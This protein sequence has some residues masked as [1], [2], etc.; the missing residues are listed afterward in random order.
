MPLRVTFELS[1]KDLRHFRKIMAA[2]REMARDKDEEAIIGAAAQLLQNVADASV[3]QF[4]AVRLDRLRTLIDMLQD[5]EWRIPQRERTRVLNALAYFADPQ[6]LIPDQTP[7]LGFLD[8]AIMI[9][10][11]A[12][13]LRHEIEAYE[14]FCRFR[15]ENG[16]P[17]DANATPTNR[18]ERLSARRKALHER[19]RR[20]RSER[21]RRIRES[22]NTRYTG[23][24]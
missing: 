9:E 13:E 24:F 20:R 23:L 5:D 16:K 8:D 18:E 14:D 7:A 11:V 1:N 6:D 3:P 22:G 2:A 4:V 17:G 21:R 12:R 15:N 19:M 10:L